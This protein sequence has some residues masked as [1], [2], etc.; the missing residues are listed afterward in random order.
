MACGCPVINTALP[1]SGVPW[2][3][4][5]GE[6]G[7]TVPVNDPAALAA[8]ALRLV[9]EPGLRARLAEASRARARREFDH[10]LMAERSLSL[11]RGLLE[12]R[13][14]TPVYE[15]AQCASACGS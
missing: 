9:R 15:A 12:G 1:G 14:A 8:A 4:R 6:T 13:P 3:S 5:D 7:L 11:Y 10:R 2:V